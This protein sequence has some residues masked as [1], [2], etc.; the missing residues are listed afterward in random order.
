MS[1]S[2]VSLP[3]ELENALVGIVGP[4]WVRRDADSLQQYGLDRT[5]QYDPAPC[6]VVFPEHTGQVRELVLLAR[7]HGLAIV[8]SGGR[9]GLSGGAVAMRGEL[10]IALERMNRI[11]D[12]NPVDRS[13]CCEAGVITAQLQAFAQQQGLFYPVDFAASGSSQIGGNVA[14]NAGGIKVIRYGLTR[15]QVLG[16]TVVTGQ[17]EIL[18]LNQGLIK[19]ATGYDL[20]HL[21][22]GSEGTLGLITEVTV[23]LIAPPENPTVMVLGIADIPALMQVLEQ[24]RQRIEPT[25]FEFFSEPALQHVTRQDGLSRPF[26]Q[27]TPFY[28]LLEFENRDEGIQAAALA[29]FGFCLE[30]GWVLDGV[31]S[32]NG[33]QAADLWRLRET[34]SE[35]IA[36]HM[37]YKNDLSVRVSRVPAFL[38][39]VDQVV[40]ERY[41]GFEVIWY[42]HIGDG[43]LHLNILKPAPL[44]PEAFFHQCEQVNKDVFAIVRRLEGSISAEHGVGLLKRDYLDYSRSPEELAYLR[45]I[46]QVFDPD[47]IMNPG[48]LLV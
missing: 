22:I 15:D 1:H 41:A 40:A 30:Q 48:K 28:A 5:R 29:A 32:Q 7:R 16:L 2:L 20:R 24:F 45:A 31:M 43:N 21:F 47:H 18:Q 27:R 26:A 6:A 13:L 37:P 42:G 23:R 39:A 44:A 34:I 11:R 17:G 46:K 3:A 38:L 10:V 25:A 14:T 9:T 36:V 8:P 35:T 12:F 33:R 19:N 4:R